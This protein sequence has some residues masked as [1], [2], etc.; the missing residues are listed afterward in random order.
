[1]VY[2]DLS[3]C[4][5]ANVLKENIKL[6][7][8]IIMLARC[9]VE[10][11]G[12]GASYLGEGDRLIIIKRDLA[13]LVH[14]P[15]GYSPVNWQPG[16]SY[17]DIE[18]SD[19]L[20]T[21]KAIRAKPREIVTVKISTIYSLLLARD[22]E[23]RAEFIEYIDEHEMR[24]VFVRNPSLI[25]PGLKVISIEKPVEPGFIDMYCTDSKGNIVVIELKRVTASK[26]AVQQL[27]R[28]VNAVKSSIGIKKV[29]GILVA[30]S[31]TKSALQ[32]LELH[33]L[34]FKQVNLSKLRSMLKE[35]KEV[36]KGR[37]RTLLSYFMESK[38][39]S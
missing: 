33:G 4:E 11:E 6:K 12:R 25:E 2:D 1:M 32:L 17:I 10:Y 35:I 28:Y 36:R 30:P 19:E 5:Y 29:R 34:E 14:R 13:F 9:S 22:L 3:L 24:D 23:D 27:A 37:E 7:N 18:C 16:S 26:E 20:L 31:I 15:T 38:A 21:I 8:L 39:R